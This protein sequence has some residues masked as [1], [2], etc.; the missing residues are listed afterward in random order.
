[1]KAILEFILSVNIV[2]AAFFAASL[3]ALAM[4]HILR[5]QQ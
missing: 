2:F 1:M 4:Y 5:K 3:G